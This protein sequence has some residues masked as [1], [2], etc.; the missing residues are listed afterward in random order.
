MRISKVEIENFL[1]IE[2]ATI[3]F[4]DNGLM[5]VE[6]W[7]YD[8]NSANGAGKSAIF[9]AICWAIYGKTP[10]DVSP[11]ELIRRG[12]KQT[13]V[14]V[15]SKTNDSSE[16]RIC[17]RRPLGVSVTLNE[18]PISEDEFHRLIET[19][20]DQF[21]LIQ[22]FSQSLSSRF[23][24][25]N[26]SSKKDLLLKLIDVDVFAN[27]KKK[28]DLHNKEL[29]N[30][31]TELNSKTVAF[32][33]KIQ[34][35]SESLQPVYSLLQE[36]NDL[37]NSIRS[38]FIAKTTL[39]NIPE[40]DTQNLV[41]AMIKHKSTIDGYH[42]VKAQLQILRKELKKLDDE[43]NPIEEPNY[44]CP[45]CSVDLDVLQNKLIKHDRASHLSKI[46]EL[47]K[48]RLSRRGKLVESINDY[49]NALSQEDDVLFQYGS[50]KEEIYKLKE[51]FHKA[52]NRIK[53]LN[54]FVENKNQR[55]QD[56]KNT[57]NSQNDL[58]I[59]IDLLKTSL[60]KLMQ[61]K[62]ETSELLSTQQLMAQILS[63]TG[64][65]AYILDSIIDSF[66]DK[67]RNILAK[68]WP[69]ITYSIL[70][71]KENKN[72][73]VVAKLSEN[74]LIDGSS[75][76]IGSLS[77][78][79]RKCL[80]LAV[81]FAILDVFSDKIGHKVSPVILDEPFDGLDAYN[82]ERIIEVL[83]ELSEDRQIVV[84]DH[85]AE[86]GALFDSTITMIK[87]SSVSSIA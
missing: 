69:N 61:I 24:D 54:V 64:I 79:E 3:E 62:V 75:R 53:E 39:S 38:A 66:N 59:K 9:T 60:D 22:Y 40:P 52:Q 68:I 15:L 48:N 25:L 45:S 49:E 19:T 32:E 8:A 14:T 44:T 21:L 29:E 20:L 72:G 86:S 18:S 2:K 5:L 85:A 31:L 1:S 42:L 11:T 41:D 10:R 35:F 57:A 82:R 36:I 65:S 58:K 84:V 51:D 28:I 56:L 13:S 37:E 7:N 83:K 63:P 76:S 70:S 55:L 27:A 73:T 4:S 6:G 12:S 17:R 26:D 47:N 74:L 46:E 77:G 80:S 67:I 34:A 33:A 81:D 43:I 78:G 30:K 87:K 71:F 50:H 23:L 16:F